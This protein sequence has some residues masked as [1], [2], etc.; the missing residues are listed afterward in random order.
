MLCCRMGNFGIQFFMGK[1]VVLFNFAK[2]LKMVIKILLHMHRK[3]LVTIHDHHIIFILKVKI[4]S[5]YCTSHIHTSLIPSL[6]KHTNTHT[7]T[8]TLTHS[9]TDCSSSV[10][11][12]FLLLITIHLYHSQ[13][14]LAHL[15]FFSQSPSSVSLTFHSVTSFSSIP[16][17]EGRSNEECMDNVKRRLWPTMTANWML[18]PL[19]QV[20]TPTNLHSLQNVLTPSSLEK[21]SQSHSTC[22]LYSVLCVAFMIVLCSCQRCDLFTSL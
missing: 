22:I 20:T 15:C 16:K 9:H 19:A 12:T 11:F 3:N 21:F 17:L 14:I 7:H 1:F 5:I 18:W 2:A 10:N 4:F 8:H 13:S 6:S